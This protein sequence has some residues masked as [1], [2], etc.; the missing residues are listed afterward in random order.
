MSLVADLASLVAYPDLVK[1]LDKIRACL[2]S[3][4]MVDEQ[5]PSRVTYYL[6]RFILPNGV[7][8]LDKL[9][10]ILLSKGSLS[11]WGFPTLGRLAHFND[12]GGKKR[13]IAICNW[14]IQGVLK[15]LHDILIGYL[16]TLRSDATYDQGKVF[17]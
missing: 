11:K 17:R 10:N 3:I 13:Y 8:T 2:S 15:P 4:P 9:L 6:R 5:A 1:Q 16:R 14:M 12:P 7:Q